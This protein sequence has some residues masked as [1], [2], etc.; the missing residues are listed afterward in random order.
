MHCD[1]GIV[2]DPHSAVSVDDGIGANEY[3]PPQFDPSRPG[4]QQR[5]SLQTA[6]VTGDDVAAMAAEAW[7]QADARTE[8][9]V[10]T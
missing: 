4:L 6:T 5:A 7:Q 2:A 1:K 3:V 10:S 9:D 8:H